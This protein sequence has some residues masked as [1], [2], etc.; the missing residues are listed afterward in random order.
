[1]NKNRSIISGID[2]WTILLFLIIALFGWVNIYGASYSFDQTSIFDFSNYAGKQFIWIITA[3]IIGVL[4]MFIDEKI[5]NVIA[6]ILYAAMILLLII[7]PLLASDIKGSYS[8]I[9]LGPVRLQ[10]AEF[11][12]SITALAIAK[13][14]GR[15]EF[16]LRDW[17]DLL[18]PFAIVAVPMLIIM[19]AQRD[20]GTALV[21]LSFMLVFYR[22]G[23]SGD[24]LLLGVISIA[25]FLIVIRFGNV[26]VPIGVGDVGSLVSTLLI[27]VVTAGVC[28]IRDKNYRNTLFILGGTIVCYG[29]GTLLCIWF[30]INFNIVGI[31]SLTY[32]VIYI[33]AVSV[34]HHYRRMGWL[35]LFIVFEVMLCQ[36]CNVVFQKVLQP[37][38]RTRFEVLLGMKDDPTGAGYNINQSLIAIGSGQFFGKGYLQGT[39]TKLRFVPEQHTDFIFCTVGEEWGFIGTAGLL[40]LY[41]ALILRIIHIAERQRDKFSMVYAYSVASILLFHLTIN[42]GMVLGLLPVIGIPLPFFSYGGSS[43]WGFTIMLSIM[44]RLDAARVNKMQ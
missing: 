43:L 15:Y 18:I 6:Y 20:T 33:I 24:I 21:F 35:V 26:A 32:V 16:R 39:Q 19:I 2:W 3:I 30:P 44:L 28:L 13:Y 23:M 11:A 1:M 38:Q 40:I 22:I 5:Y 12:K 7:T 27:A 41:L 17:R 25:L 42:I 29:I 34:K 14:I 36:L 10:P 37:H 31:I 9:P 4:I 8:W